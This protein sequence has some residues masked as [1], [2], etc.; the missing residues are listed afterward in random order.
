MVAHWPLDVNTGTEP[1]N[2]VTYKTSDKDL[3]GSADLN[4]LGYPDS[5][6][7]EAIPFLPTI[8]DGAVYF[9]GGIS[10]KGI[11]QLQTASKDDFTDVM[12]GKVTTLSV[13]AN[14][15]WGG[16]DLVRFG[17]H[18]RFGFYS[19][20]SGSEESRMG[21][22]YQAQGKATGLYDG[23]HS[24]VSFTNDGNWHH[25]LFY[26][27]YSSTD[28]SAGYFKFCRD[29]VCDT[30]K[31]NINLYSSNIGNV[32]FGKS[33][34]GSLKHVKILNKIGPLCG[35]GN[36]EGD[37]ECDDGNL[38]NGDGC[39]NECE[40]D[41]EVCDGKDN[42]DNGQIDETC[43]CEIV[44]DATKVSDTCWF[45]FGFGKF[46]PDDYKIKWLGGS[47]SLQS[48]PNRVWGSG[49]STVDGKGCN[50]KYGLLYN[51][52]FADKVIHVPWPDA[53]GYAD[54]DTADQNLKDTFVSFTQDKL[55]GIGA[56]IIDEV[57][58]KD[59][60]KGRITLQLI[61]GICK[62]NNKVKCNLDSDCSSFCPLTLWQHPH[63]E[64]YKCSD[65]LCIHDKTDII[66]PW[67]GDYCVHIDKG[68]NEFGVRVKEAKIKCDRG[69]GTTCNSLNEKQKYRCEETGC[70]KDTIESCTDK[71]IC[72]EHR[73]QYSLVEAACED[74]PESIFF[75]T[76]R[77]DHMINSYDEINIELGEMTYKNNNVFYSLT[78]IDDVFTRLNDICKVC[79]SKKKI[80]VF[81]NNHGI[82]GAML[83][84]S[85]W[86]NLEILDNAKVKELASNMKYGELKDCFEEIIFLGCDIAKGCEIGKRSESRIFI[87]TV[88][89]KWN[90]D[91]VASKTPVFWSSFSVE[92]IKHNKENNIIKSK[93][94][95]IKTIFYSTQHDLLYPGFSNE[96]YKTEVTGNL[97]LVTVSIE[98]ENN[99][100]I[101]KMSDNT[102][103]CDYTIIDSGEFTLSKD[104]PTI[105][106]DTFT[107]EADDESFL[108]DNPVT[109][110]IKKLDV[111]CTKFYELNTEHPELLTQ[112]DVDAAQELYNSGHIDEAFFNKV[113]Y[114]FENQL[115]CIDA[116]DC[117]GLLC[118][119]GNPNCAHI[120]DENI[121][122]IDSS[123]A[124]NFER[125]KSAIESE[126][127]N[128]ENGLQYELVYVM[129]DGTRRSTFI[130]K[131]ASGATMTLNLEPNQD[132]ITFYTSIDGIADSRIFN[133][134]N[135]N[136]E[137]IY[138]L[139][140]K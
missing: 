107:I 106:F 134:D 80:K 131:P 114:M 51:Y 138:L 2:G 104:N 111:D 60:N 17:S 132:G 105:T 112:D 98:D 118:T 66:N 26:N 11:D 90:T 91:V 5:P 20:F 122:V 63:L 70:V 115:E 128:I 116:T 117:E 129:S 81:F 13:W 126:T 27:Y 67:L 18:M 79:K 29:G 58:T 3:A 8:K 137:K 6:I 33:F 52:S 14:T 16:V 7:S 87:E 88:S 96:V 108:D 23:V 100:D 32:V 77:D 9:D 10:G 35:D 15:P 22:M 133:V 109:V 31:E 62:E 36:K 124:R 42:N 41:I 83:F 121:C 40:Y 94:T 69:C 136:I 21:L 65:G 59:E 140:I 61:G 48:I 113:K 54:P 24:T 38:I 44:L 102:I 89:K 86:G 92:S 97:G 56:A 53:T 25:Y 82:P 84:G 103:P 12:K 101:I 139:K 125:I 85:V 45:S 34:R 46:P 78:S 135:T 110:N 74:C 119:I 72:I 71:P 55:G 19:V 39:N 95:N 76:T 30:V 1:I 50:N 120:C 99:D 47:I 28:P 93:K 68:I 73:E 130:T 43:S 4:Y 57:E 127:I 75:V 64:K 49:V 37:E 123:S